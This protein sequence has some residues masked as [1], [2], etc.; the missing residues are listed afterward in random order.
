[1]PQSSVIIEKLV[2]AQALEPSLVRFGE[3]RF[4]P[5]QAIATPWQSNVAL[6]WLAPSHAG[7][8]TVIPT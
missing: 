6:E 7:Q 1:M 3:Q 8:E 5:V 2:A 4:I